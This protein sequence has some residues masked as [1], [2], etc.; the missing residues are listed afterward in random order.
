MRREARR[1]VTHSSRAFNVVE[2]NCTQERGRARASK[3][4]REEI[5]D[6]QQKEVK[7][8]A[9]CSKKKKREAR[10]SSHRHQGALREPPSSIRPPVCVC[11][12]VFVVS[13]YV[14]MCVRV[15]GECDVCMFVCVCGECMC[16]L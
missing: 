11:V 2:H 12:C 6:N 13:V 3:R 7:F 5:I 4:E 9:Y 1:T 15:C 16:M 8:A 10:G 14:C